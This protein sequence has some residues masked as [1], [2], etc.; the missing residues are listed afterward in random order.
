[1]SGIKLK[2]SI[3]YLLFFHNLS[4]T[5]KPQMRVI[6]TYVEYTKATTNNK[7]IRLSV[8]ISFVVYYFMNG[9]TDLYD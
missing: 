6:C 7:D 4:C 8:T 5:R 1:M 9:W 2:S 3:V